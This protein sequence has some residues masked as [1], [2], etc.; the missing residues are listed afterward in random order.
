MQWLFYGVTGLLSFLGLRMYHRHDRF[1]EVLQQLAQAQTAFQGLAITRKEFAEIEEKAER[2][3]DARHSEN[4]ERLTNIE[5]KLNIQTALNER[6]MSLEK[7]LQFLRD[8]KHE[9]IDPYFPGEF[10]AMKRQLNRIELL[11]DGDNPRRRRTD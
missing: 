11:L 5:G 1:E 9:K 6:L 4:R 3:R 8:W 2:Y 10:D 7:E